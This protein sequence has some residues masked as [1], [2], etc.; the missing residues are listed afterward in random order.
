MI[1]SSEKFIPHRLE[2]LNQ[3]RVTPAPLP[4]V[5]YNKIC[6]EYQEVADVAVNRIAYESDGLKVTG[7]S[8]IPAKINDKTYPILIYNRG[9]NREF[10]RLTVL[11]VIRTL[12]PFA[13][14]G[15]LVYAS[16]YRGN[17]GG[18]GSEEFGGADVNDV[19]N[20]I[21][22]AKQ[23]PAWD[24]KNIFMQGHSRGGMMTYLALRRNKSI[25]AAISIAGVSDLGQGA[26]ERPE[27]EDNVYRK[28]IMVPE[29]ERFEAYKNRSAICWADEI[30]TPL[31]LLHGD[32]DERVDVCHSVK[33]AEKL[34]EY[35]KEHELVIYAGGN[36]ALLR[37]WD[38]VTS[39][40]LNWLQGHRIPTSP[41][42]LEGEGRG[43]GKV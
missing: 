37:F 13:R 17:D 43:E 29:S 40:S 36:H 15:Y 38:D 1:I 11:A 22:A 28:L 30:D 32:A 16:N 41:S 19:L 18:E 2:D 35:N 14:A 31:L 10:G 4:E 27:M 24:G 23:N 42:P 33:M 21:E 25:N 7:I 12:V 34:K 6:M 5:F 39:K 3:A 20:L 8:A 26:M 9:G